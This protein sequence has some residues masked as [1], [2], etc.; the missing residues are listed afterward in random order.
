MAVSS[1][2]DVVLLAGALTT[3]GLPEQ[4]AVLADACTGLS[5]PVLAVL[6]NHDHHSGQPAQVAGE[7][8][9]AG[10]TVLD[11]SHEILDVGDREVGVVGTKG[12]VGGFPGA[13][14]PDLGE[15]TLRQIY[16]ETS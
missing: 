1:E 16:R 15:P 13:E 4:A 3:H 5:V 8:R 2:C 14:I 9:R 12:F 11:R 6:G 7:L 10:I